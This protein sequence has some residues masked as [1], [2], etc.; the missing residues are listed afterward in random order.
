M[1]VGGCIERGRGAGWCFRE[2]EIEGGKGGRGGV[3]T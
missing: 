3:E 1:E 2:R